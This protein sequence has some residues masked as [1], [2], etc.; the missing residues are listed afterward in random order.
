[1]LGTIFEYG[2]SDQPEAAAAGHRGQGLFVAK[3][4]MAKMG[5][6]IAARNVDDGVEFVL[7]LQRAGR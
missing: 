5:G 2:V 6:T 4:Y 7:T 3:T 1:M